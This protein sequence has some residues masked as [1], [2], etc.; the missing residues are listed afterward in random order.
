V[1]DFDMVFL[2]EKPATITDASSK[3]KKKK[4]KRKLIIRLGKGQRDLV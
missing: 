2:V 3:K 4:K 1:L